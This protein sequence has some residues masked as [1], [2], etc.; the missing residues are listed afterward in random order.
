MRNRE[1]YRLIHA[2]ELEPNLGWINT[3]RPLRFDAELAGRLVLLDFWTLCCINCHHVLASLARLEHK[4]RDAPFQVIGVHSAKFP[5]EAWPAAVK[6][7]VARH[8]I[9]HPV[10]IDDQ[11]A[12][13]RKYAIRGWPGLVLVDPRGYLMATLHGE[14]H[15]EKLD[16]AIGELLQTFAEEGILADGPLSLD[17]AAS[18][19]TTASPLRFPGKVRVQRDIPRLLISDTGNHRLIIADLPDD[20]GR[21]RVAHVVGDGTEGH[22]DGAFDAARF[23]RPQ[24]MDAMGNRLYVADTDNHLLRL[25]DLQ[26]QQVSTIAGTGERV[27]DPVG[28]RFGTQQGISSPWDVL[29]EEHMMLMAMAGNHQIWAM[30]TTTRKLGAYAGTGQEALVDRYLEECAFAQPSGLTKLHDNYYVADSET[31]AIREIVPRR[32]LVD[33]LVG[34]GLF[35]FGDEDGDRETARLQHPLGVAA[36]PERHAVL[37]ADTY[38]HKVRLLDPALHTVHT[39]L[40]TGEP[41]EGEPGGELQLNEPGGLDTYEGRLFIADTGN[42]RLVM[43][44]LDSLEWQPVVLDGLP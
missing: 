6:A 2:P 20:T 40:G 11:M 12:I 22:A 31:S 36:W 24:G 44:D 4:Y 19:S 43:V 30:D 39:L 18:A 35:T 37:I 32:N 8:G 34:H 17:A 3:P 23:R 16:Q 27:F 25:I 1:T 42:H 29:L 21:A 5:H 13:W 15:E 41:G 14:G 38:N 26:Q 10:V 33:T 28:G 9:A 7:A